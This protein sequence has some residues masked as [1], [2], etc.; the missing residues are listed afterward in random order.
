MGT[1][2]FMFNYLSNSFC[3][4]KGECCIKNLVLR[5]RCPGI[6]KPNVSMGRAIWKASKS[7]QIFVTT[8]FY[9]LYYLEL[10]AE[11]FLEADFSLAFLKL[12]A[13]LSSLLKL[14][15]FLSWGLALWGLK[16]GELG[17]SGERMLRGE[18][19]L[20]GVVTNNIQNKKALKFSSR[21]Y[22]GGINLH[23]VWKKIELKNA[24]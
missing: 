11:L 23:F 19:D 6:L 16:R 14:C 2:T 21:V 20:D 17:G 24:R 18:G 7:S 1:M 13:L 3:M 8:L 9:L 10:A 15:T 22:K 4:H 12:L 5:G